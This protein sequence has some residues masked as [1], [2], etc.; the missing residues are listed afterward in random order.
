MLSLAKSRM[1]LDMR[2]SRYTHHAN[3]AM[4]DAVSFFSISVSRHRKAASRNGIVLFKVLD[5]EGYLIVRR[6]ETTGF[7]SY[8]SCS[9][10][11]GTGRNGGNAGRRARIL[12]GTRFE[13]A[14]ILLGDWDECK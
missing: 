1:D 10:K 8:V 4:P 12:G 5:S 2:E 6:K 14:G 3:T 7:A 13:C 9:I 11:G